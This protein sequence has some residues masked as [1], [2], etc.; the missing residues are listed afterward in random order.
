MTRIKSTPAT[1]AEIFVLAGQVITRA[2]A[3]SL[4]M[5]LAASAGKTLLTAVYWRDCSTEERP[6]QTPEGLY[7]RELQ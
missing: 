2:V 1:R 5:D 4:C 7:W 3:T 6:L